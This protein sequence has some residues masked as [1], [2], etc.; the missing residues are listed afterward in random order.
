MKPIAR[1]LVAL[2]LLALPLAAVAK[3]GKDAPIEYPPTREGA[4]VVELHGETIPD[5]YRWLEPDTTD[6][7]VAW[8]D[9]QAAFTRKWLDAY[10]KRDALA[11]RIAKEFGGAGMR[12]LPTIRA[13]MSWFTFRPPGANHAVLYRQPVDG[14]ADP[15][16]VLDPNTWNEEGT[17]GLKQWK[18][19]PDGTLVAYR[20]DDMGSEETTLY[21]RDVASGKNLA[22]EIPRTKHSPLEWTSDSKGVY[23]V[24]QPDPEMVPASERQYH[25]RVFFHRL[26]T[27]PY[28]DPEVYG[29]GRPMIE[30][31]WIY[32]SSD[33]KHLFINRGMPYRETDTFE[34]I[35]T[36]TGWHLDPIIVGDGSRTWVDRRGD[37]Y[38][39]NTDKHV[40]ERQIWTM[41]RGPD[42]TFG[43][44]KHTHFTELK[45]VIND[46]YVV[47]D[48]ILVHMKQDVVSRLYIQP[49]AGGEVRE[50]KLPS[51][52]TVSSISTAAGESKI[53]FRFESYSLP[54][55]NYSC[56]L[57][58]ADL[59]ITAHEQLTTTVDVGG[60][61]SE[62]F[63]YKSKDGTEIPIFILRRKDVALDGRAP[64]VL[65]GYGG[66]RVGLYPRFSR[67]RAMWAE[68]GG[69]FCVA[70]LRGGDEFGEA[71]HQAGCLANKQNVYDDFIAGADW[72]VS[73]GKAARDRLAVEGG[74]NGGLLTAVVVNQ[75]P[76]LCR[77]GISSVPLTDMLRYHKFQFAKSWTK[78][79]GDPDVAEEFKW[80]RPYSPYHNATVGAKYPAMLVKAGLKDGRV[81]AYHARKMAAVWQK[82]NAS[83]H[84]ILYRVDRKSGH[85]ASNLSAY[86]EELLD[87]WSF[88]LMELSGDE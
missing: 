26:G 84:P 9:A 42:G 61:V 30:S 8:D 43:A 33:E 63:T 16:V 64:T 22:D 74:S 51:P 87:T 46:S 58:S 85:G 20:R 54:P 78:E 31:K 49:V 6:E 59:A 2:T 41:T 35:K 69:V 10:P 81:N 23:Y 13:G 37:T 15:I 79:Y 52:G 7:V 45:G 86:Q 44:W 65:Y 4:E 73:S 80:I 12:S 1:L 57:A 34:V 68:L 17:A 25:R 27:L 38:I 75:R 28:N 53:W 40:G 14:S 71:W 48:T 47:G 55:T 83:N 39:L 72:L 66:F 82:A 3:E 32:K 36:D 21:F 29:R 50:I 56:D 11:K 60:L 88:L 67:S 62:R 70:N 18:V 76:D 5:P 19:S 77:A 24:R